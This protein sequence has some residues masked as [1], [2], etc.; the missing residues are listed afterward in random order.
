MTGA[1]PMRPHDA[2]LPRQ[3][4]PGVVASSRQAGVRHRPRLPVGRLTNRTACSF[5]QP[6]LRPGRERGLDRRVRELAAATS[7]QFGVGTSDELAGGVVGRESGN[8]DSDLTRVGLGRERRLHGGEA[9]T[10]NGNCRIGENAEELVTA[11]PN[12]QIVGAQVSPHDAHRA[13]QE[14]VPGRMAVSVIHPFQADH[15]NIGDHELAGGPAG[16]INLVVQIGETGRACARP[17]HLVGL[18]ERELVKQRV[19]VGLSLRPVT[20]RLGAI[21]GGLLA[22]RQG[23]RSALGRGRTHRPGGIPLARMQRG[24]VVTHRSR[25]IARVRDRVT[26]GGRDEAGAGGPVALPGRAVAS[27][28]RHIVLVRIAAVREVTVAGC[29]IFVGCRLIV[30]RRGLIAVRDGLV[31]IRESLVAVGERPI[32]H[33]RIGD[34]EGARNPTRS[35]GGTCGRIA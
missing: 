31:A 30:V 34:P 2:R 16:A 32:V 17:G 12:H 5:G 10:G 23:A 33:H 28:A 11:H 20:C 1:A 18:G 4:P 22:I 24:F 19:A 3:L 26:S 15:I 7:W 14:T 9:L 6:G 35:V 13:L 21:G 25:L 8:A 29:L 27:V